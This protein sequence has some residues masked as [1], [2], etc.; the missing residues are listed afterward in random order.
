[1]NNDELIASLRSQLA[2]VT[3]ER[4]G[5]NDLVELRTRSYFALE[6][7][8]DAALLEMKLESEHHFKTAEECD[9]LRELAEKVKEYTHC[10]CTC[11]AVKFFDGAIK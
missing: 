2:K 8:R 9:A 7:E 1:M 3:A 10:H 5:L 4:D 6:K 11:G